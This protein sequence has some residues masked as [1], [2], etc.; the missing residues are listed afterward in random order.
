MC[1]GGARGGAPALDCRTTQNKGACLT[2]KYYFCQTKFDGYLTFYSHFQVLELQAV[3][4]EL[5]K[6]M[7]LMENDIKGNDPRDSQKDPDLINL[8]TP[9]KVL[10]S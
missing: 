1:G 3:N 7:V 5:Q 2:T 10:K 4:A 9:T 8:Y 6:R